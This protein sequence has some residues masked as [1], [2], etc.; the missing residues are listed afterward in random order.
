MIFPLKFQSFSS[1]IEN[2][3]A[4]KI[5]ERLTGIE[6]TSRIKEYWRQFVRGRGEESGDLQTF[7]KKYGR[8][9]IF[10]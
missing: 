8:F 1:Y 9:V 6:G 7:Q 10:F 5:Y 4:V 3:L 2:I